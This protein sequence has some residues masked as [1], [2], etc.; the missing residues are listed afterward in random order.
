MHFKLLYDFETL[1]SILIKHRYYI[2]SI[3][4]FQNIY[5]NKHTIMII[6]LSIND[7]KDA[8]DMMLWFP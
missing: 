1:I 3:N 2:G 4:T 8:L 7:L 6:M 5:K